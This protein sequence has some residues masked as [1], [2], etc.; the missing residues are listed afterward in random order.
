M[1]LILGLIGVCVFGIIGVALLVISCI[2]T[3]CSIS[4]RDY[5][6]Y[7]II[8]L[9]FILALT[10]LFAAFNMPV[11]E[12]GYSIYSPELTIKTNGVSVV[13]YTNNNGYCIFTSK[14]TDFYLS[15]N[16]VIK[17]MHDLDILRRNAG[18]RYEVL[19]Y[20]PSVEK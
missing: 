8:V 3:Y 9:L 10:F 14:D 2:G 7:P 13:V 18:N 12:S 19:S 17:S 11:K 5:K 1:M 4:E 20:P 6:T 15:S 16:I